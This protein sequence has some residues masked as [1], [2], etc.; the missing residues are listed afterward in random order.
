MKK[1]YKKYKENHNKASKGLGDT[2]AKI[3]Q[4]TGIKKIVDK[5]FDALGSDCG[6]Q[7]RQELWNKKFSYKKPKC[8]TEDEYN[9][10]KAAIETKK[11]TFNEQEIKIYAAIFERI[12]EKKVHC[13]PCSFR[14]EVWKQLKNVYELYN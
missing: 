12:F 14:N 1:G 4:A 10:M 13:Q 2:V 11:S 7:K 5:T 6:C 8:F 9:L 3:T